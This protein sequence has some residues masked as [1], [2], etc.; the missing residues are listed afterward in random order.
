MSAMTF[1]IICVFR[2]YPPPP[3]R[4]SPKLI[5]IR[6]FIYRVVILIN[7]VYFCKSADLTAK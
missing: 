3:K 1:H 6:P 4:F 7:R 2:F 5:M